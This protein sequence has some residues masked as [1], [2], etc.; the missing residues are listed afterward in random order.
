MNLNLFSVSC[1]PVADWPHRPSHSPVIPVEIFCIAGEAT[2]VE[3]SVT[4]DV[5]AIVALNS[6]VVPDSSNSV[7]GKQISHTKLFL[8]QVG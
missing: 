7:N 8:Q 4:F 3:F 1:V 6:A 5:R 2:F